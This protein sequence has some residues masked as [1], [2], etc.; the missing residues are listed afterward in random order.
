[1]QDARKY[2]SEIISWE[3]FIELAHLKNELADA[4]DR[5][6]KKL[7]EREK[8]TEKRWCGKEAKKRTGLK[9]N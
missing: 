6:K 9:L 1:M 8:T 4:R 5:R 7:E 3:Y 2:D